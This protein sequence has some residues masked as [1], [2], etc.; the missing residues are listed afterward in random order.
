MFGDIQAATGVPIESQ[1]LFSAQT[2]LYVAA[3]SI[4][5]QEEFNVFMNRAGGSQVRYKQEQS[6]YVC[7]RVCARERER[8]KERELIT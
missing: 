1:I 8:E 5:T 4:L 7:V 2:E 3:N 6:V